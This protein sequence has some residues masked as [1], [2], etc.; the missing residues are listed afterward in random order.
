MIPVTLDTVPYLVAPDTWLIPTFAAEPSGAYFG[1]HS[2]VIRGARAG[3]RRHRLFARPR[4][5]AGADLQR[6]RSRRRPVGLPVARRPRP[7]RQPRRRARACARTPRSCAT[8]RSSPASSATSNCRS[9]G[10]AGSTPG[11]RSTSATARCTIVRPPMFDSPATRGLYDPTTGLLWAVDSFGTFFPGEVYEAGDIPA[12]LYDGSFAVLNGWNTPW[13]EWVDAERFAAHVRHDRRR[14]RSRSSPAPT[15]RSSAAR[16]IDDAFRRTLD[17]AGQPDPADARPGNARP[18]R[19]V[20][21]R[22]GRLTA[23]LKGL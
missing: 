14:C 3:H 16:Q 15:A 6:R 13:L 9:S 1:A 5:L 10:C 18:A 23:H 17:L 22:S 19:L 8:S 4:A 7:H 2:L 11:R 12:D 20:A 21:V